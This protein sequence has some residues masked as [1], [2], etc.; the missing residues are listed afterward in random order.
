[1]GGGLRTGYIRM[2]FAL[3]CG[4]SALLYFSAW[5]VRSFSRDNTQGCAAC[6]DRRFRCIDT[7]SRVEFKKDFLIMSLV[8]C[9]K[10][11]S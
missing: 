5:D 8:I 2:R 10:L 4:F 7:L 1:M 6:I 3:F 9:M 11:Y